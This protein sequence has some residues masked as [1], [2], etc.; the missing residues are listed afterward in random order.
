MTSTQYLFDKYLTASRPIGEMDLNGA[1][2]P[3]LVLLD[4]QVDSVESPL[5]LVSTMNAHVHRTYP[6]IGND[7]SPSSSSPP[8]SSSNSSN[9]SKR[10]RMILAAAAEEQHMVPS[11]PGTQQTIKRGEEIDENILT[12]KPLSL[13]LDERLKRRRLQNRLAA[14]S[15]RERKKSYIENLEQQVKELTDDRASLQ[16]ALEKLQ[17]DMRQLQE[18]VGVTPIDNSLM[19]STINSSVPSPS[20]S[21]TTINSTAPVNHSSEHNYHVSSRKQKGSGLS[22]SRRSKGP[23]V[24][25]EMSSGYSSGS[26]YDFSRGSEHSNNTVAD[27]ELRSE[28]ENDDSEY[29]SSKYVS[30]PLK[31]AGVMMEQNKNMESLVKVEPLNIQREPAVFASLPRR[32]S[33]DFTHKGPVMQMFPSQLFMTTLL[34]FLILAL[35]IPVSPIT[36]T[37]ITTSA[38]NF[39]DTNPLNLGHQQCLQDIFNYNNFNS[40]TLC[41]SILFPLQSILQPG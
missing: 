22:S 6:Y 19:T 24:P 12:L 23:F 30:V 21:V 5:P 14:N 38:F 29:E 17:R 10:K 40:C 15:C 11:S 7:A 2:L 37:S 4:N 9:S 35:I 34:P 39:V 31:R 32:M 27:S 20:P 25:E 33:K 16:A 28:G 1:D 13:P 18:K 3:A 26:S 41:P 36:A 8:S